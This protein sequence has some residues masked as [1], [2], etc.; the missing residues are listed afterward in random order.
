MPTFAYRALKKGG[1]EARGVIDADTDRDA[2]RQARQA[3]LFVTEMHEV[4]P[5][6]AARRSPF[7]LPRGLAVRRHADVVTVMCRQM[8]T[9]VAADVPLVDMLTV[10]IEQIESPALA[11]V[12]RDVRERVMGGSSL[13]DALAA[14]PDWFPEIFINMVRAGEASGRLEAVLDALA[15]HG[16]RQS[17]LKGRVTAALIYPAVLATAGVL[18][19]AFLVTSVVPKFADLLDRAGEALP[20]P[21]AILME[22]SEFLRGYYLVVLLAMAAA[23]VGWKAL[24]RLERFRYAMDSAMLRLPLVGTILRKQFIAQ[25]TT[26]LAT[27]LASGIRVSDGLTI[28]GRVM[29]NLALRAAIDSLREEIAAGRDIASTLKKGRVFPPL[30]SHMIAVGERSG[31]LEEMLRRIATSYEQEVAMALQKLVAVLEPVIVVVLAGAVA[32]IV[33]AILL[34]ILSLSQMVT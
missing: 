24:K 22:V 2:R 7:A 18:V 1:Q 16:E 8:A 12:L 30:V 34:P 3:G 20:L 27:L 6:S 15:A 17:Q 5:A 4:G 33:A 31:R 29:D 26:T 10:V 21:T 32:F 25:F 9:L 23:L 19:V 14:H 13:H 28:A 11:L